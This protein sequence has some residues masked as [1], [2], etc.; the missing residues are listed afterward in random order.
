MPKQVLGDI[1]G[2]LPSGSPPPFYVLAKL[3]DKDEIFSS[4][5]QFESYLVPSRILEM[6][7]KLA[8]TQLVV[9]Q[10]VPV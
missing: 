1:G 3:V 4:F 8:L 6:K 9:A 10:F 7:R 5:L 2:S